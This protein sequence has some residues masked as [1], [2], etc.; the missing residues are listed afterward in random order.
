VRQGRAKIPAD[1][2]GKG[3]QRIGVGERRQEEGTAGKR[4][5]RRKEGWRKG[6]GGRMYEEDKLHGEEGVCHA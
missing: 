4:N 2:G 1:K 6:R 5:S 3:R